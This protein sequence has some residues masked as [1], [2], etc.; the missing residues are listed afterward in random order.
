MPE[1]RIMFMS[2]QGTDSPK[3]IRPRQV[4]S[5]DNVLYKA[6]THAFCP[7]RW[8]RIYRFDATRGLLPRAFV[9][10]VFCL[11]SLRTIRLVVCSY[12]LLKLAKRTRFPVV[13][14]TWNNVWERQRGACG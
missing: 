2:Y 5:L 14:C 8:E 6:E 12:R 10:F 13:S 3:M 1:V 9:D 11:A 7:L 4:H